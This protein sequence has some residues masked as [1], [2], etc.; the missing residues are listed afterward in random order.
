MSIDLETYRQIVEN[1]ADAIM[2]LV[3]L[4]IVFANKTALEI[5]GA[6][7]PEDLIGKDALSIGLLNQIQHGRTQELEM[8]RIRGDLS[9]GLFEFPATMKDGRAAVFEVS[10]SNIPFGEKMGAL[11]LIR[12]ITQRKESES[13]LDSLHE[14]TAGLGKATS[15]EE[16]VDIVLETMQNIFGKFYTAVGF[17]EGNM[18][19]F[20]KGLGENMYDDLSLDGPGITVRA[21]NTRQT[22]VVNDVTKDPDY[23]D[24]KPKD[25]QS[26]SELDVPIIVDGEPVALITV[27]EEK[28]DSFSVEEVQLVEILGNHFASALGRIKHHREL[29][30]M[31]E[32]H[33][34]ELVGGMDKICMR[35][36]ADL[37]GPLGT[38]RN[39]SFIIRHNPELSAEVIDNI[40]NSVEMMTNTLE[41]MKE[42]TSP[43]EPEKSIT[44]VFSVLQG[45]L[46]ISYFPRNVSLENDSEIGF[47]AINVDKE[48]IQRVFFN[49]II[50]AIEAMP[51]GGTLAIS[52]EIDE[53]YVTFKFRDT[54]TGIPPDVLEVIYD[55]FYSTKPKSL[56]LGLSF[57]KLAVE[58]TGG[59]IAID[60]VLGEGTTVSIS[61]PK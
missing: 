46:D 24:G 21:I 15:R 44:D 56:G 28:P 40:D 8:K 52:H 35:V 41:E 36:Q 32:D 39:S 4:K 7:K 30:Q 13:R 14:S 22:Q 25:L 43:T 17:V 26:G 2:V 60:S 18:L 38:I 16:A 33:I 3:D 51:D 53:R 6:D 42:I 47:L 55:P 23:I 61:L 19:V 48:K 34:M 45:A 57:C 59:K 49:I 11:C 20:R 1:S 54:G 27:E 31:R 37:K 12:D 50:N 10:I 29:M 5:Y 9:H 58:S